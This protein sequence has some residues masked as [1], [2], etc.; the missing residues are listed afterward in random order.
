MVAK[1]NLKISG[2]TGNSIMREPEGQIRGKVN[3]PI[4]LWQPFHSFSR[5]FSSCR[6]WNA[7]G[8]ISQTPLQV[9]F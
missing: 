7:K 1:M 5:V 2:T 4:D 9:K 8:Y 6:G 3:I